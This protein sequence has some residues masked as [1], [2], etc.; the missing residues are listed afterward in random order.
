MKLDRGILH[1]MRLAKKD[2]QADGW[3]KVSKAVW[4]AITAIPDDLIE[5]R[6]SDEG[7]HVRLTD[8]GDAI[9]LYS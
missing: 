6:P 9:V 3:T 1:M 2:A 8:R 5:K 4:P 7:G